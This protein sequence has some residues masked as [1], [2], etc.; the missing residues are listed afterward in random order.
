M[1]GP[2]ALAYFAADARWSGGPHFI[3]MKVGVALLALIVILRLR[4]RLLV[5]VR[6][7]GWRRL[8]IGCGAASTLFYVAWI[9]YL[10]QT[11][12]SVT[13]AYNWNMAWL[14]LDAF[15]C[16]TALLTAVF[17]F[18]NSIGAILTAAAFSTSLCIDALFDVTTAQQGP[19]LLTA[20]LEA[21][22]VELPFAAL[23]ATL[24]VK[25]LAAAARGNPAR[26]GQGH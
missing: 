3:G 4:R 13:V 12:P 7:L 18:R 20:V 26:A 1:R 6:G 5:R 2:E 22:L 23:S 25:L 17:L 14:A 24:A 15:E 11:M 10:S 9:L 21:V 16:L 19:P 8:A